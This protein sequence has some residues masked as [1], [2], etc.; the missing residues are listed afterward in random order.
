MT[1]ITGLPN[2]GGSCWLNAIIQ[3]FL[4]LPSIL[5]TLHSSYGPLN[6]SLVNVC[7]SIATQDKDILHHY[8]ALHS[9][10]LSL[11]SVFRQQSY[12]DSQEVIVYI[13]NEL[14]KESGKNLQPHIIE[15]LKDPASMQII[16]DY[17]KKVSQILEACMTC[18]RRKIS[19]GTFVY[20]TFTLL[21]I[22]LTENNKLQEAINLLDF[23]SLPKCLLIT[24][25]IKPHS[26][27][28]CPFD[29]SIRGK[30]YKLKSI[31]FY[32]PGHY[33]F[34]KYTTKEDG[35]KGWYVLN[36]QHVS[37]FNGDNIFAHIRAY[38][39]LVAYEEIV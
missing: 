14:H 23:V 38:P 10:L 16:K 18:T 6:Q 17:D 22:D 30:E 39:S 20:E 9:F 37:F 8:K 31:I 34:A 7:N 21:Y 1:V 28:F 26:E 15:K 35:T 11:H 32:H 19:D 36:D 29:L 3:L 5:K 27:F 24:L 2:I 4:S 13:I 25:L 12:N 33:F